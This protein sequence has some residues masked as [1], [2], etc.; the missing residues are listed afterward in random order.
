MHII[1]PRKTIQL[2]L[3]PERADMLPGRTPEI[4]MLM[5][6]QMAQ[7]TWQELGISRACHLPIHLGY[8]P[9]AFHS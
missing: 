3:R 2:R 6:S 1:T 7:V 4:A 9:I 5:R 8:D